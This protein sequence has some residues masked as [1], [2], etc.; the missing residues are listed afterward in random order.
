MVTAAVA[1]SD[2]YSQL[3]T[4]SSAVNGRPS[5]HCTPFLSFQ[6][7]DMPSAAIPPFSTS[8]ISAARTGTRFPSGSHAASGSQKIRH[9]SES[10]AP[11]A[12][13]G[14]SKV[15]PCQDNVLSAPPPPALF[16]LYSVA[17]AVWA[18]PDLASS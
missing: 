15:G 2:A 4:T 10:L 11:T 12:K 8:G 5:C 18:E 14:L 16:G 3:N 17:A 6:V 9:P 1:G 7:T 13:W